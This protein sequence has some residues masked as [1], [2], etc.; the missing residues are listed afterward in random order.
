MDRRHFLSF[1]TA[2]ILTAAAP[3]AFVVDDGDALFTVEKI[4]YDNGLAV[5]M[6]YYGK[7]YFAEC[8]DCRSDFPGAER[9]LKVLLLEFAEGNVLA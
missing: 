5:S 8:L 9:R 3:I 4:D 6:R 7:R 1:P 2:A